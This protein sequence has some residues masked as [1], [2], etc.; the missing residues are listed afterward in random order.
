MDRD[1]QRIK[2][3]TMRL[4]INKQTHARN[5]KRVGGFQDKAYRPTTS[6]QRPRPMK[7]WIK[8]LRY[9]G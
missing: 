4:D 2:A 9:N 6:T 5:L 7:I 8:P 1:K 3:E